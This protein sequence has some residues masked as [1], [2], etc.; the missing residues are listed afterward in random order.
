M[1]CNY[2]HSDIPDDSRF[3][4]FCGRTLPPPKPKPPVLPHFTKDPAFDTVFCRQCGKPID[5][6]TKR[7]LGCG[8]QYFRGVPPLVFLCIVLA[9][10]LLGLMVFCVMQEI[11]YHARIDELEQLVELYKTQT[12]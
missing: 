11:G 6:D 10:A 2:C 8:K 9:L 3:C 1:R 4:Q 12:P 7:C 5:D